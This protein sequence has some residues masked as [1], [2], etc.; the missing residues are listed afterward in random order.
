[1]KILIT[2]DDKYADSVEVNYDDDL[3]YIRV[4]VMNILEDLLVSYFNF[5]IGED[6]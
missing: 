5:K 1:M 3:D 4:Q 2:I 6:I